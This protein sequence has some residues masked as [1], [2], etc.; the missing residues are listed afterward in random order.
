MKLTVLGYYGGYPYH[1]HGTSSYLITAGDGYRLLL[2]CGS[3]AL[4]SLEK[5]MDPLK[6]DAVLLSHYHQ[7]HIADIGVL[8][9]Y[10]QLKSGVKKTDPLKIY[11]HQEDL[12]NFKNLTFGSFTEGIA[13]DPKKKLI[14]GP[15]EVTF[16]RTIHPVAAFAIRLKEVETGKVLTYTADTRYFKELA[17]FAMNS[18]VLIAD[19]NFAGS[20]EGDLWHMTS[21]QSA[22]L[23][24]DAKAKTLVLSHLPQE[25]PLDQILQEAEFAAPKL[26][27]VLASKVSEIQF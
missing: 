25:I 24:L 13:Y 11:G 20:Q 1:D 3:G 8:Q 4:I 12:G 19:T 9:Y 10:Y 14:L 27:V 15:L 5:V 22:K 7:D 18:D 21:L 23:A 6:L 2:D 16:C 17:D 26:E